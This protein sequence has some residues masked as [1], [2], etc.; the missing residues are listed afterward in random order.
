[1]TEVHIDA[2]LV[3]S[4]S[5]VLTELWNSMQMIL[6]LLMILSRNALGLDFFCHADTDST[7]SGEAGQPLYL[8]LRIHAEQQELS[9]HEGTLE[10]FKVKKKKGEVL[11]LPPR[12]EFV[13]LNWTLIINPAETSDSGSYRVKVYNENGESLKEKNIHLQIEGISAL[14]AASI[15]LVVILVC[16]ALSVAM[17]F[18]FRKRNIQDKAGDAEEN[19]QDVVYAGVIV[20]KKSISNHG[21]TSGAEVEYAEVSV[22]NR[23]PRPKKNRREEEKVEYGEVKVSSAPG[24]AVCSPPE[25]VECVYSDIHVH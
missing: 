21:N 14:Q 19:C 13:L 17:F 20:G 12:W 11:D 6:V 25:K 4:L 9:F 10:R 8:E 7:C 15:A 1:M 16:L 5:F 22:M 3:I 2:V 24:P 23:S 18:K